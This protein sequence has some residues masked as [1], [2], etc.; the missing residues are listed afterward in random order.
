MSLTEFERAITSLRRQGIKY[1]LERMVALCD[2][3]GHPERRYA[4]LHV[5]G[6]NGK[7]ST[8]AFLAAMLEAAGFRVG[9]NTSPHLVSF[10][11]RVRVNGDPADEGMLAVVLD[12]IRPAL[13]SV[14]ASFFEA[15]TMLAFEAFARTGVDVAVFEVGLGGR[16]DATN[17]IEPIGSAI[18]SLG[19]EHT[20]IL[21]DT[22]ADIAREKGGIIKRAP[23]VSTATQPAARAVLQAIALARGADLTFVDRGSDF[24]PTDTGLVFGPDRRRYALSLPGDHQAENAALALSLIDRLGDTAFEV[25]DEARRIGL[26][27]ARWPGRFDRRPVDGRDVIFDVAHNAAGIAAIQRLWRARYGDLRPVMVFGMLADKPHDPVL[28]VLSGWAELLVVT[29]P[30][31][32]ERRLEAADMAELCR[33]RGFRCLVEP[34]PGRAVRTAIAESP[35]TMPVLV[36]GSLFT[37]GQAMSDLGIAPIIPRATPIAAGARRTP[38]GAAS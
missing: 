27:T 29:T 12:E 35:T 3:L 34:V 5:A 22:I 9:L 8:A 7:G 18:A 25:P 30:G 33:A 21:G 26:A 37:V 16:L 38:S 6:T 1:D 20:R 14:D 13:E 28:D 36:T 17:V 23:V 10:A 15:T 2:R 32:P 4:S 19:L 24:E 31:H 11:E